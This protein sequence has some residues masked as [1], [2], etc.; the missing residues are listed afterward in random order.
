MKVKSKRNNFKTHFQKYTYILLSFFL[1]T[2]VLYAQKGET[3]LEDLEYLYTTKKVWEQGNFNRE[4]KEFRGKPHKETKDSV[5]IYILGESI[6]YKRSEIRSIELWDYSGK[7]DRKDRDMHRHL[8]SPTAINIKKGEAFYQNIYLAGNKFTYGFKDNF[9]LAVG[10]DAWSLIWWEELIFFMHPRFSFELDE[11]V[12]FGCGVMAGTYLYDI[13]GDWDQIIA[14][15]YSNLTFGN[16]DA[17]FSIGAGYG[18]NW[19][20]AIERILAGM[21]G[22]NVRISKNITF[23]SEFAVLKSSRINSGYI[24]TA[25][26]GMGGFKCSKRKNTFDLGFLMFGEQ[27]WEIDALV[28][29]IG[30]VRYL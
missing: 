7:F 3:N 25:V 24:E 20:F 5:W 10:I 15:A 8:F 26:V 4:I 29:Y 19:D 30:Y 23:T 18:Y 14:V 1:F 16:Q 2:S 21:L 13:G 22:C 6:G 17:N 9:S 11:N 27:D 28:P 12:R